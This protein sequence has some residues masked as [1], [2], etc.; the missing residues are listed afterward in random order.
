MYDPY[1]ERPSYAPTFG[2][3][4][5]SKLTPLQLVSEFPLGK[6]NTVYI[7]MHSSFFFYLKLTPSSPNPLLNALPYSLYH[8]VILT[9]W[10]FYFLISYMQN[11]SIFTI[12]FGTMHVCFWILSFVPF[13]NFFTIRLIGEPNLYTLLFPSPSLFLSLRNFF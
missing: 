13:L 11:S 12:L 4:S 8:I 5:V 7:C 6:Q 3:N 9:G 2:P 1:L 10:C